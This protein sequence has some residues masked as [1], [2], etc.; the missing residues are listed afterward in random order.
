MVNKHFPYSNL[1]CLMEYVVPITECEPVHFT[2]DVVALF[3]PLRRR[4]TP[5]R[6]TFIYLCHIM[7]LQSFGSVDPS[8]LS[9]YGVYENSM[10]VVIILIIEFTFIFK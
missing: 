6:K 4:L 8:S 9:S 2:G 10:P 7:D 5:E 3:L 1:S